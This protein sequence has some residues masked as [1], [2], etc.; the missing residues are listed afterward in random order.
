MVFPVAPVGDI[1]D[2]TA[3]G[4]SINGTYIACLLRGLPTKGRHIGRAT[5]CGAGDQ[6]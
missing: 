6:A 1:I 4:D 3:A 5:I 2:T